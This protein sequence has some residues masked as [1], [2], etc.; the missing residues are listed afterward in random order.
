MHHMQDWRELHP[1]IPPATDD[2]AER[3]ANGASYVASLGMAEIDELRRWIRLANGHRWTLMVQPHGAIANGHVFVVKY[4]L[5]TVLVDV[6]GRDHKTRFTPLHFAAVWGRPGMAVLL[7][8]RGADP[9]LLTVDNE[10]AAHIAVTRLEK[11]RK[12][13]DAYENIERMREEGQELAEILLGVEAQGYTRWAQGQISNKLVQRHSPKVIRAAQRMSMCVLRELVV[14][15]RAVLAS[16]M[17]EAAGAAAAEAADEPPPPPPQTVEEAL[18]DAGLEV[19]MML[20]QFKKFLNAEL[21]SELDRI[22]REDIADLA[23][24][25]ATERREL[26]KFVSARQTPKEPKPEFEKKKKNKKSKGKKV[27]AIVKSSVNW[28]VEDA[29]AF[30]FRPE[31]PDGIFYTIL[32]LL[33]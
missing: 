15:E 11:L 31:M 8:S 13:S 20:R 17:P 26:W 18:I 10:T 2:E 24:L 32:K 25:D 19:K 5:D 6:N 23:E 27:A 22:T 9:H 33:F 21:V 4:L 1:E 30:M 29:V 14:R 3:L 28:G 16:T 7:L 12:V